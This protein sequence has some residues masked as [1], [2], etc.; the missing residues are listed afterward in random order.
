MFLREGIGRK[1]RPTGDLKSKL[2]GTLMARYVAFLRG[3][4]LGKRR[5]AMADLKRAFEAAKFE[6]VATFIASGNV[7]FDSSVRDRKKL[8]STIEKLLETKFGFPVDTFVRTHAEVASVAAAKAFAPQEMTNEANTIHVGFLKCA[9]PP[10]IAKRFAAIRTENDE[11]YLNGMD[12][13]W[14]CRIK[15][16]ESKVWALPEMRAL[17]LPTC[18]MRNLTTVRKIAALT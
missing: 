3:I 9:L 18:S 5:V 15:T 8:E 16:N 14:L 7:L 6:N 17:K 1:A 2:L 13:Y 12:F 4:N 10:D 11:F